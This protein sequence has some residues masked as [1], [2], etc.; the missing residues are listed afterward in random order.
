MFWVNKITILHCIYN[1][2]SIVFSTRKVT[3][4]LARALCDHVVA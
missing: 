3:L 2:K 1:R 4:K